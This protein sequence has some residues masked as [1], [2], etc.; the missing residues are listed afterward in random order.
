MASTTDT[1]SSRSTN[2][3]GLRRQTDTLERAKHRAETAREQ[4]GLPDGV[5]PYMLLRPLKSLCKHT[6]WTTDLVRTLER[7]MEPIPIADWRRARPVN[8]EPV[9][10]LAEALG[11]SPRGF[12]Y[13]VNRLME[14]GA[15][16]FRD[17]GNCHRYPAADGDSD[18]VYGIDLAPCILLA[19]EARALDARLKAERSLR[20][21]LR[22]RASALRS[23]L[24]AYL[25]D[26]AHRDTLADNAP[27]LDAD[28]DALDPGRFDRLARAALQG[29][30]K[31]FTALLAR[32]RAL[33][34][35][36]TPPPEDPVDN[37]GEAPPRDNDFFR[38]VS[39]PVHSV[40]T[41]QTNSV[42]SDSCSP[43]DHDLN[44]DPSLAQLV[45]ALPPDLA[46]LLPAEKRING[47]VEFQDVF[48]LCQAV[49]PRLGI[50]PDAWSEA[51]RLIGDFRR[52]TVLVI[53][54]ARYAK[55][56]PEERRVR[57]PGAFFR[58]LSR[59][60]A[61]GNADLRASIHGIVAY[62]LAPRASRDTR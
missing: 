37:A 23:Q 56:W 16:S 25:R 44:N 15:L 18:D 2:P 20:A 13:R 35:A 4:G 32:C 50:A 57:D 1:T 22:R 17:S 43:T 48:R 24:R 9:N 33:L 40:T 61:G 46:K 45:E 42:L 21:R 19:D 36:A 7:L 3:S 29:L 39:T 47:T 6:E 62:H 30:I 53:T 51:Y 49:R 59:I 58:A 54:A 52:T 8:W 12:Q 14:L 26:P 31:R 10:K 34:D 28:L 38:C 5:S 60:A 11:I 41:I 55:T 27:A